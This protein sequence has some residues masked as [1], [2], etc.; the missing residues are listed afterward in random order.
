MDAGIDHLDGRIMG[1]NHRYHNGRFR[2]GWKGG[3]GRPCRQTEQTYLRVLFE[4]VS[5]E[6]WGKVCE[7]ALAQ[8]LEGDARARE[9]LG[10]YLIGRPR[11]A[12]E[13]FSEPDREPLSLGMIFA[14]IEQANIEPEIRT[15]LA[16]AFRELAQ[17]EQ[18]EDGDSESD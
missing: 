6:D 2:P 1:D 4:V 8:A 5:P 16:L 13:V 14:A 15:K 17:L 10:N 18:E 9:W 3:P 12:V 7:R 11:Q